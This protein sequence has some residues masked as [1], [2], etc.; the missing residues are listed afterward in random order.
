[1]QPAHVRVFAVTL[2]CAAI[3]FGQSSKSEYAAYDSGRMWTRL[4]EAQKTGYLLGLF[5]ATSLWASENQ[6]HSVNPS[7]SFLSKFPSTSSTGEISELVDRFYREP[8]N[9]CVPVFMVLTWIQR[10]ERGESDAK[11]GEYEFTLRSSCPK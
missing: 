3:S 4:T 5:H 6:K 2:F 7:D 8:T 10:K 9:R 11:L 1:M